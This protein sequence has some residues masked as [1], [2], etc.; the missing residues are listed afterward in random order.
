MTAGFAVFLK[1]VIA[2][3]LIVAGAVLAVWILI[4]G[5]QGLV[6]LLGNGAKG[7]GFLFRHLFQ[8]IGSMIGDTFRALGALLTAVVLLPLA[9]LNLL[10]FRWGTFKHYGRALEDEITSFALSVYRVTFGNPMRFVG[11]SAITDGVERRLPDVVA[12][13]PRNARSNVPDGKFDGY[14]VTGVLPA[15]G[16]GA[17]L[18]LAKPRAEK[19]QQLQDAGFENPGQVVIKAFSLST[20]STMPQIVRESRALE[21]ARRLGLILEHEL[22]E[23]SFHYVMP[24]VPGENMDAVIGQ[25]HEKSGARGLTDRQMRVALGYVGDL[26]F[27]LDAYHSGGL[28]HKDIKPS[29]LIVSEG[30]AHL[31]DLGL[32]TPLASAMTL[33]THGT[34]YYRD[35]EMVRQALR[36]VKVHEV[37]GAKFDI[38]STGAVLYSLIEGSFPAQGSLSSLTRR[39]PE[40]VKWI[41]RRSMA[42]LDSRYENV[43]EMLADIRTVLAAEDPYSVRPADLPSVSGKRDWNVPRATTASLRTAPRR[44]G[45]PQPLRPVKTDTHV[46]AARRSTGRTLVASFVGMMF[47]AGIAGFGIMASEGEGPFRT[48]TRYVSFSDD[49]VGWCVENESDSAV[50]EDED[51]PATDATLVAL[52]SSAEDKLDAAARKTER[53]LESLRRRWGRLLD[54]PL[55]KLQ[56][57]AKQGPRAS[58]AG[59]WNS[60]TVLVLSDMTL[61]TNEE[62]IPAL[63]RELQRR[64]FSVFG[65]A[66]DGIG[67]ERDILYLAGARNAIGVGTLDDDQAQERLREYLLESPSLDAILWVT[68]GNDEGTMRCKFIA[69]SEDNAQLASDFVLK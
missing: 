54:K 64:D 1:V 59:N 57:D 15:G 18:F 46:K 16:S 42:D 61:K 22:T 60:G 35:P 5:T 36:G 24:Y 7:V 20:G 48:T 68:D 33:T 51:L 47:L 31:V 28:W 9:L 4:R 23:K 14:K 40:V 53:Q 27:T 32:V 25:M 52:A 11:M 2:A 34:E 6:W 69:P 50:C 3:A 58:S 49:P 65:T 55:D 17:R 29:N 38:Y 62:W 44:R 12:R 39:T 63:D 45:Q 66:A 43:T 56:A 26:L 67:D 8:F 37:D 13:A 19:L 21:S 41:I 30:R 10:F